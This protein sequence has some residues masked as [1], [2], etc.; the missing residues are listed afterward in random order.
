MRFKPLKL[1]TGNL[2]SKAFKILQRS[3]WYIFF[4]KFSGFNAQVTQ[5]FV[6]TFDGVTA[7]IGN[8]TLHLLEHFMSQ[9]IGLPQRGERWFKKKPID[10]KAWLPFIN[11]SRKAHKWVNSISRSWLKKPWDELKFQIQK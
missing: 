3:E 8:L 1:L 7:K 6:E 2:S 5:Q 9:V 11:K 4:H 10:E